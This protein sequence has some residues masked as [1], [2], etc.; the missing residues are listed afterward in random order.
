MSSDFKYRVYKIAVVGTKKSGKTSLINAYMN[1]WGNGM[2]PTTNTDMRHATLTK[3]LL[4]AG[5][6][7]QRFGGSQ[8]I[9]SVDPGYVAPVKA[10]DGGE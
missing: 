5:L 7:R 8:A 4:Q 3:S 2:F 9:L 6:H 10:Q 1:S